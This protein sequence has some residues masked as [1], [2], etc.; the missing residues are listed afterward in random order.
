MLTQ[1]SW[2]I[3]G[4]SNQTRTFLTQSTDIFKLI[5]DAIKWPTTNKHMKV[6]T[7]I[8]S[9]KPTWRY[10]FSLYKMLFTIYYNKSHYLCV[11][12]ILWKPSRWYIFH[13]LLLW[14][15]NCE[16]IIHNKDFS[17]YISVC[18]RCKLTF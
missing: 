18:Y 17:V 8:T 10:F 13:R 4:L 6:I 14:I 2:G 5:F 7:F 1:N 16:F 9:D 11:I 12:F 3:C 15:H